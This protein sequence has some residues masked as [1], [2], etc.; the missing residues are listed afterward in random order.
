MVL[1]IL[2]AAGVITLG[3]IGCASSHTNPKHGHS[4]SEHSHGYSASHWHSY[5]HA[6]STSHEASK[7]H[8]HH[9][10]PKHSYPRYHAPAPRPVPGKT[11]DGRYMLP[12]GLE[13]VCAGGTPPPC[14]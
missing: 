10:A 4:A 12:G 7:G 2:A 3:L 6:H 11:Q 8:Y 13:L 1:R 14:Q 5:G 9:Y